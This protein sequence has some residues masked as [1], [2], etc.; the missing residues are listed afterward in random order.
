MGWSAVRDHFAD[1]GN[2]IDGWVDLGICGGDVY[3]KVAFPIQVVGDVYRK[4]A[5]PIHV[6]R[7]DSGG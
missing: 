5:F 4:G 6:G 3:R 2:M 7:G 1:V